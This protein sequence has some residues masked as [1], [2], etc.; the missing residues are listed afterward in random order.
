[1]FL[2]PAGQ[3]VMPSSSNKSMVEVMLDKAK[4]ISRSQLECLGSIQE[5]LDLISSTVK[6]GLVV[7]V[8]NLCTQGIAGGE[9][10]QG[11]PWLHGNFETSLRYMRP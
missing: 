5:V 6:L 8:H 2:D 10:V 1:M 3:T 7:Q 9:E 4:D 11:H